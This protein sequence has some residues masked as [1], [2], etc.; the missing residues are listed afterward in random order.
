MRKRPSCGYFFLR[1][2]WSY[3]VP[4]R[5]FQSISVVVLPVPLDRRS[6]DPIIF[7]DVDSFSGQLGSDG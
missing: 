1:H 3:P 4:S 5:R 2:P 7:T 6:D